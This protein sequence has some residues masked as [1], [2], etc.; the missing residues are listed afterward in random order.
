MATEEPRDRYG[1]VCC[2][3]GKTCTCVIELHE[4]EKMCLKQYRRRRAEMLR[5]RQ[6]KAKSVGSPVGHDVGPRS[7]D[8]EGQS[9]LST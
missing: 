3:C 4:H 2:F 1:Y 5:P 6:A 7:V 9:A 8:A